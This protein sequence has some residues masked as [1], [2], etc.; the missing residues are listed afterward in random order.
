ML[1]K[2]QLGLML[3][4]VV[5]GDPAPVRAEDLF[6]AATIGGADALGRSDLGR[7]QQGVAA[8]ISKFDLGR[9]YIPTLRKSGKIPCQPLLRRFML[10]P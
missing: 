1:L 7:L 4:R 6:D 5:E 3:C 8:D 9:D 10:H 2:L